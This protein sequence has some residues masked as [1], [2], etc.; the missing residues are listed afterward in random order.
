VEDAV[1]ATERGSLAILALWVAGILLAAGGLSVTPSGCGFTP[2]D[3][4]PS[5]KGR[6]D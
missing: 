1:A 3:G 6:G 5:R 2:G 4:L